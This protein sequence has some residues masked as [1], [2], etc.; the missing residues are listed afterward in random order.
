MTL[1]PIKVECIWVAGSAEGSLLLCALRTG[2]H[3]Q[4]KRQRREQQQWRNE[5]VLIY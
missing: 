5:R 2:L 1:E 3:F 4:R